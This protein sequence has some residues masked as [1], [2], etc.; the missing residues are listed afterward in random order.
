MKPLELL[1]QCRHLDVAERRMLEKD[2]VEVV[3]YKKDLSDWEKVFASYL[4]APAKPPG[5]RSS[6][7]DRHVTRQSGG[8]ETNQTLY[9]KEF[10][11]QSLIAMF[12]P[13]GDDEHVTLKMLCRE[14]ETGWLTKL[15]RHYFS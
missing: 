8:I 12:W 14:K 10:D 13:W 5:N 1:E 9:R 6:L 7:Y 11:S 3:F 2:Y 4:G 15:L